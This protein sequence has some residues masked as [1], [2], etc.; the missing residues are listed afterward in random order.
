VK[1]PAGPP[2]RVL[3]TTMTN[4]DR[5]QPPLLVWPPTLCVGGTLCY[6]TSY[7]SWLKCAMLIISITCHMGHGISRRR[8]Y[9]PPTPRAWNPF[10]WN[11]RGMF[12][13]SDGMTVS[14]TSR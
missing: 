9:L 11:A 4:D 5:R 14:V 12:L 8:L 6:E 7:Y 3:Q 10:T 1:P 13:E 2:W